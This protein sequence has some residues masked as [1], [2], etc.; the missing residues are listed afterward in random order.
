MTLEEYRIDLIESLKI[1]AEANKTYTEKEFALY[2]LQKLE[3]FEEV[4]DPVECFYDAQGRHRRTLRFDGYAFDE[5]DGSI[6]MFYIDFGLEHELTTIIQTQ[7]DQYLARMRNFIEE[8]I[9]TDLLSKIEFANPAYS[10]GEHIVR[11]VRNNVLTKF[12]LKILTNKRISDK[13]KRLKLEDI[14]GIPVEATVWDIERFFNADSSIDHKEEIIVDFSDF[15][16]KGMKS[17]R[18]YESE[19]ENY[20]SYLSV[21]KGSL[22]ADIYLEFGSRL[23]EGNV[24]SFLSLRGKVNKGI[25]TTI[26]KEPHNFFTYNNGIAITATDVEMQQDNEGIWISKIHDMQIINGGQTTASLAYAKLKEAPDMSNIL[27][28]VK[29]TVVDKNIAEKL[30]PDISKYANSQNKVSD[31]DFFANSPFHIRIEQFSRTLLAPPIDGN[32]YQ[33]SWYYERARG[34]Y[35]QEQMKLTPT[36][37]KKFLLKNPKNQVI[38]KTDLAKFMN[39]FYR[40]PDLVSLGAQRNMKFFAEMVEKQWEKDNRVFN[41]NYFKRLIAITILYKE[42][43]KIVQNASWYQQGY[44]ANIVTYT[45]AKIFD[46]LSKYHS[47]QR[48]DFNQIWLNQKI[49]SYLRLEVERIGYLTLQHI[50]SDD[51]KV[52]NVTEWCKKLECWKIFQDK[53]IPL[54]EQLINQLVDREIQQEQE[55]ESSKLQ[56]MDNEIEVQSLVVE[57]GHAYWSELLSLVPNNKL[58]SPKEVDLLKLAASMAVGKVPSPSQAKLILHIKEKLANKGIMVKEN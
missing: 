19:K 36:Q 41:Q 18:A 8:I 22:L 5:A 50:T 44:R 49:P 58:L 21:I 40:R 1:E 57:L 55:K 39:T 32:Q 17:V 31:A 13:V 54:S 11:G 42:S 35:Q 38:S 48:L 26:M 10:L 30:I 53:H 56:K 2:A 47:K 25:N 14:K 24:R 28:P 46:T 34:Q 4:T 27:V 12:K 37:R 43:E 23:L 52:V 9:D 3:S 7:I 33:T 16:E 45:L 20:V 29:L 51:R 15:G 6:S